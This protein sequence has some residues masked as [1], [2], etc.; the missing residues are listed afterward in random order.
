MLTKASCEVFG[1]REG[2]MRTPSMVHNGGWYN[3]L[4]DKIGWGDLAGRDFKKIQEKLKDD[5]LFVVL[6]EQESFWHF[7]SHVGIIGSMSKVKPDE[8]K[9]GVAYIAE[10]ARWIIAKD[11]VYRPDA[12]SGDGE[13]D[14]VVYKTMKRKHV[15]ALLAKGK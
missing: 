14:G 2:C 4:S 13:E 8:Q 5:E 9:P 6:G 15:A 3:S 1:L 12:Y 7:V 10:H 11:T